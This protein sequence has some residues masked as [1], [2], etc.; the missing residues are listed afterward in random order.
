[1][2]ITL[3]I[4]K[5]YNKW[6]VLEFDC[7]DNRRRRRYICQCE[8]GYKTSLVAGAVANGR[9]KQCRKCKAL[10]LTGREFNSWKVLERVG[11]DKHGKSAW[12]CECKCGRKRIVSGGNLTSGKSKCC[13]ECGHNVA[14]GTEFIPPDFWV[15]MKTL[16]EIRKHRWELTEREAWQAFQ[17]QDEKCAITGMPITFQGGA[18]R[19]ASLDRINS[20]E[21]YT[22]VNV[23]WVHKHINQMKGRYEQ[24]YFIEMC[25]LVA[26]RWE[27]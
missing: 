27:A 9:T 6:L 18:K 12:L 3:E 11:N 20:D 4:N 5:L 1:M 17:Q 14:E 10:H 26:K 22:L 24:S 16:A 15:K 2:R 23:Q 8:C 13:F 21:C 7:V 25:K 19:T